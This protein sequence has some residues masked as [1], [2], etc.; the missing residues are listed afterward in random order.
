M[1]NQRVKQ[2]DYLD[3]VPIENILYGQFIKYDKTA[4]FSGLRVF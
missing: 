1:P 3:A 4:L 2:Y